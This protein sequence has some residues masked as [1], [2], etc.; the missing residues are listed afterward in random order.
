MK[1]RGS[2]HCVSGLT[3][4]PAIEFLSPQP[5]LFHFGLLVLLPSPIFRTSVLFAVY[6]RYPF[7]IMPRKPYR[8]RTSKPIFIQG[9]RRTREPV[10]GGKKLK[11]Q[12][13]LEIIHI[14]DQVR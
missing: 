13:Y 1:F 3:Y 7:R 11:R 14:G 12:T 4:T 5:I 6:F 10:W 2:H 8:H 9:F